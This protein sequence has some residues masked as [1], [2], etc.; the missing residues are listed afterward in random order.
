MITRAELI[1]YLDEQLEVSRFQDYCPNGLQVEGKPEINTLVTGV[2]ASQAL[3]EAAVEHNAD[4]LMVHHGYFWRGE[5]PTVTGIKY[6]RLKMLIN[7]DMNL[8]GYHLP[9]D[10]HSEFGNN[11]QL[12]KI[13]NIEI[14]GCDIFIR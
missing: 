1:A 12:A 8:I 6:Q 7:N 2:T 4:A 13:L 11:V 9:L 3:L 14:D 10:A 5:A